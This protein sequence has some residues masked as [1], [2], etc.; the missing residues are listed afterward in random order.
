MGKTVPGIRATEDSSDLI[1][2]IDKEMLVKA[3]E[4]HPEIHWDTDELLI[5]VEINNSHRFFEQL[6]SGLIHDERVAV[7][8]D[9]LFLYLW[10]EG[11]VD[12]I[13]EYQPQPKVGDWVA[14]RNT[15]RVVKHAT[16]E[17][18]VFFRIVEIKGSKVV[19][20]DFNSHSIRS[21]RRPNHEEFI[22]CETY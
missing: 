3:F 14:R 21:L 11:R 10:N 1:I 17:K 18:D 16:D 2:K 19:G 5:P 8:F 22:N 12:F 6:K 7:L 4:S 9:E 15:R 20:E 13:E